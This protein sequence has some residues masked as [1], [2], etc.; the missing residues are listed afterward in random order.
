MPRWLV[1]ASGTIPIRA[2]TA[3]YVAASARPPLPGALELHAR[4]RE[5]RGEEAAEL[6]QGRH[7]RSLAEPPA[8]GH[9]PAAP[10]AQLRGGPRGSRSGL[11]TLER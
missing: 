11:P 4:L 10:P 9:A 5:I 8:G 3:T 2:S 1:T 7:A 6:P